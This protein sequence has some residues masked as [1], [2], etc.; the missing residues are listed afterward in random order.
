MQTDAQK[1]IEVLELAA[2]R[3]L[4][5]CEYTEVFT[6]HF[7]MSLAIT[8]IFNKLEAAVGLNNEHLQSAA[9]KRRMKKPEPAT[10]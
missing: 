7:A 8:D 2:L 6:T 3:C 5:I 4:E 9:A 1:R 10:P